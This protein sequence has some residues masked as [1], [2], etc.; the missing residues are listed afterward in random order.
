MLNQKKATNSKKLKLVLALLIIVICIGTESYSRD[1]N[2]A[3]NLSNLKPLQIDTIVIEQANGLYSL[4]IVADY[5]CPNELIVDNREIFALIPP[6]DFNKVKKGEMF[7]YQDD[8]NIETRTLSVVNNVI[9]NYDARA[10]PL[11]KCR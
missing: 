6:M 8:Q 4:V 11:G 1:N 10:K 7:I 3:L 2:A 5:I 9:E